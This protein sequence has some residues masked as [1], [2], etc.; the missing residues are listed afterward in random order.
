MSHNAAKRVKVRLKR[1]RTNG[2]HD[3]AT[4]EEKQSEC[5]LP[6]HIGDGRHDDSKI[7]QLK[8]AQE[9]EKELGRQSFK[10]DEERET[11]NH[12]L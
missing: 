8:K 12:T 6:T 5:N 11:N 1:A 7:K 9:V 4:H 3:N 2:E 10:F